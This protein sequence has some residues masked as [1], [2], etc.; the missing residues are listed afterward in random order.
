MGE[1]ERAEAVFGMNILIT[2]YIDISMYVCVNDVAA[3][4]AP[5]L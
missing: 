5:S 4:S 2:I 3:L 1:L